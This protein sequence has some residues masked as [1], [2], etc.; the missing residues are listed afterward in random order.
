MSAKD[1]YHVK[2]GREVPNFDLIRKHL[3]IEGHITKECLIRILVEVTAV[4]KKEPNLV[5]VEEPVIIIGDIHG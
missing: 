2:D 4:L 1:L 3:M 5:R